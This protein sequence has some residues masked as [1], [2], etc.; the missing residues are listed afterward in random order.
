[1]KKIIIA[2]VS[3]A[4]LMA[5]PAFAHTDISLG[6]GLP[7]V[8]PA[9]VAYY[10]PPPPYAYAP[11]PPAYYP[12]YAYAPAPYYYGGYPYYGGARYRGYWR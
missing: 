12:P 3:F 7:I 9:P 5:T 11:P 2:A 1:M 8:A 10:P 4:G 6:I